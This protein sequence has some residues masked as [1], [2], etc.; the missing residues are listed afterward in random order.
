M[1]HF[2]RL[3][4]IFSPFISKLQA[5][6]RFNPE[7]LVPRGFGKLSSNSTVLLFGRG[8]APEYPMRYQIILHD[9]TYCD[10]SKAANVF[11]SYLTCQHF[12]CDERCDAR[13][14][15]PLLCGGV[16]TNENLCGLI[17]Q[18]S[19]MNNNCTL[20]N[21]APALEFISIEQH[22]DWI[23]KV[24]AGSTL[25]AGFGVLV[26]SLLYSMSNLLRTFHVV[27]KN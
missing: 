17:M 5:A 25:K 20:I 6:G 23:K 21:G 24:S 8:G 14:G 3:I 13:R 26:M 27:I 22:I 11:C 10:A 16:E 4:F 15:S 7:I 19:F 12:T 18:N 2:I 9:R 1:R